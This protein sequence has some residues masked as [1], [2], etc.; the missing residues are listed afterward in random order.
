MKIDGNYVI[1]I[2]R[3]F[4]TF[5]KV[6]LFFIFKYTIGQKQQLSGLYGIFFPA[7]QLLIIIIS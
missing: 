6:E 2:L 3:K 7:K 5:T 1:M 4:R